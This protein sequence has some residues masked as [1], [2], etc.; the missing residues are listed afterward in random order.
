MAL[1]VINTGSGAGAGDGD[2]GR[3]AFS[4]AK[5]NFADV[6]YFVNVKEHGA[7]G[8][9][10]ADDS[11]AIQAA[12]DEC[13]TAGGGDV[14]IPE[15][16]FVC[17]GLT[18]PSKVTFRGTAGSILKH[19]ASATLELV[20]IE[21]TATR[22]SIENL[23][24][25][26]NSPNITDNVAAVRVQGAYSR[27]VDVD[28][29]DAKY[30]AIQFVAPCTN[31]TIERCT[32]RAVN[33][34]DST[35]YHALWLFEDVTNGIAENV[36]IQ[37]CHISDSGLGCIGGRADGLTV[38]GCVLERPGTNGD[39]VAVY[40]S[41][42]TNDNRRTLVIG[43]RIVSP[44]N[45]G[46]HVGGDGDVAVVGNII[47]DAAQYGIIV[48]NN[49]GGTF[50]LAVVSG[51]LVK[52]T[53][54]FEG[55]RIEMFDHV[56][57]TGNTVSAAGQHGIAV[58][59]C[60]AVSVIGNA[61]TGST[62][63]GI[64]LTAATRTVVSG[65]SILDNLSRGIVVGGASDDVLI[66]NNVV[67]NN[68]V[69]QTRVQDTATNVYINNNLLRGT[70]AF[71]NTTSGTVTVGRNDGGVTTTVAAAAT[72]NLP[73][74]RTVV[75]VTGNTG[76]TSI[77]AAG[78]TGNTVTLV[79]TGTPTVTDGSNLKLAGNFVAAGTTNDAD[80]LTLVCDGTSWFEVARS[81][82]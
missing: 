6:H 53:T 50:N 67:D 32:V 42:T 3:T 30:A 60:D 57:V 68:A 59:T 77:S 52:G 7:V 1:Q 22:A 2:P 21:S 66:A 19:K 27:V 18:I 35:I 76:I 61:I 24:I 14:F 16:T 81:T 41:A 23:T 65:N 29:Y 9:G 40:P 17:E 4:K 33:A 48:E 51:N 20:S 43:N 46:I 28:I 12:I 45:N 37:N 13:E 54:N 39:G 69:G 78:Q 49:V 5:E 26:G 63:H 74:G 79:F 71:S 56:S 36:L 25:D 11:T 73:L 62:T 34:T 15:G 75:T 47:I 58:N 55:I 44:L 38:A 64:S 82:N 8:D 80:T 31:P 10:T 70:T 72:L